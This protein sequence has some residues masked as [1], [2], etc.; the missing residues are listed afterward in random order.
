MK[1]RP[2]NKKYLEI[3]LYAFCLV[4]A[5]L[6]FKEVLNSLGDLLASVSGFLRALWQAF[7]ALIWGAIVAYVFFPVTHWIERKIFRRIKRRGLRRGLAIAIVYTTIIAVLVWGIAFLIPQL[8][9]NLEELWKHI[10]GYVNTAG[11]FLDRNVLATDWW[12]SAEVQNWLETQTQTLIKSLENV[13]QTLVPGLV[14]YVI[15]TVSGLFRA[16]LVIMMSIF[17]LM[18]RENLNAF[19]NRMILSFLSRAR[20]ARVLGFLKRAD[21][22]FGRYLV[23]KLNSALALSL[24]AYI[25]MLILGVRYSPLLSL[26]VGFTNLIPYIGPWIG[27]VPILL[28]TLLDNPSN[29]VAV[30]ILLVV[31]QLIDNFLISPKTL[32]D[33]MGLSP[34][35]VML[36][37]TAGGS[38]FG[39]AGMILSV[40]VIALVRIFI[41][42]IMQRRSEKRRQAGEGTA[43]A[44]SPGPP[45]E[46]KDEKGDG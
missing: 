27:A 37:V 26:I 46:A 44:P 19:G 43:P 9:L 17:I 39:V 45:K 16:F 32:S 6:V 40:P 7:S 31:L 4:A 21:M 14:N 18:D 29:L 1:R 15:R 3:C 24:V 35:W 41:R 22:V 12:N 8:I 30:V 13:I 42:E 38:L 5:I 25:G 28:I 34:F 10:P 33:S 20:A 11:E 23:G 2:L 36:G